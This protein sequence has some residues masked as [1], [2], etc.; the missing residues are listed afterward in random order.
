M[1]INTKTDVLQSTTVLPQ[2][3][4]QFQNVAD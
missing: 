2:V 4:T 1:M 3:P